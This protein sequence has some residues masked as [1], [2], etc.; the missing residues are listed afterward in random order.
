MSA[1]RAGGPSLEP[2]VDAANVE[3]VA[4]VGELPD[5]LAR[6]DLSQ[7]DGALQAGPGQLQP[8]RVELDGELPD[9]SPAGG[10][11][12]EECGEGEVGAAGEPEGAAEEGV[13]AERTD[14]GAEEDG[15]D[16][17]YFGI[18]SAGGNGGFGGVGLGGDEV[19]EKAAGRR[20]GHGESETGNDASML[21]GMRIY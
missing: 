19:E 2:P 4:A 18:E 20:Y 11:D 17:F 12:G 10:G 14:E 16:H 5:P 1:G 3:A 15:D 21:E 8:G 13:D 9:C 7:T 6:L